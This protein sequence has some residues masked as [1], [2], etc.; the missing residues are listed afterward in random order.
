MMGLK[1]ICLTAFIFL[2]VCLAFDIA[3]LILGFRSAVKNNKKY[4]KSIGLEIV[5]LLFWSLSLAGIILI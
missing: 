2:T 3:F 5:M 4:E 1:F